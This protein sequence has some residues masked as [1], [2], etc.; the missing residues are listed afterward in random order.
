LG[1]TRG[2]TDRLGRG[3]RA[4]EPFGA[5]RGSAQ[6]AGAGAPIVL[7]SA[8]QSRRA[9]TLLIHRDFEATLSFQPHPHR[10]ADAHE[11]AMPLR[12]QRTA[13]MPLGALSI[14]EALTVGAVGVTMAELIETSQGGLARTARFASAAVRRQPRALL[15]IEHGADVGAGRGRRTKERSQQEHERQRKEHAHANA[16][17]DASVHPPHSR[18]LSGSL[19]GPSQTSLRRPSAQRLMTS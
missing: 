11:G 16:D 15:G 8:Q 12:G 2:Q 14:R 7:P 5:L 18:H 4:E 17:E 9:S 13:D 19:F 10:R 1:F 6:A 3:V